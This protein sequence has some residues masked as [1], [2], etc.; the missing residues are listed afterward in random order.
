MSPHLNPNRD[1]ASN[2][3]LRSF[4][5][6]LR[7][8]PR[9]WSSLKDKLFSPSQANPQLLKLAV[10]HPEADPHAITG[11]ATDV[12]FANTTFSDSTWD[13]GPDGYTQIQASY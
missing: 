8:L 4:T 6:S 12:S 2:P 10:H 9:G 5:W 7:R 11:N 3:R 1:I 13:Y